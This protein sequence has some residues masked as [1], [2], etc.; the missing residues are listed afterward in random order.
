[1]NRK[2]LMFYSGAVKEGHQIKNRINA[3]TFLCFAR[4]IRRISGLLKINNSRLSPYLSKFLAAPLMF[5]Q[6]DYAKIG[7]VGKLP[8]SI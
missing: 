2:K 6:T 5:S 3:K 4:I 1:M 8:A 7:S